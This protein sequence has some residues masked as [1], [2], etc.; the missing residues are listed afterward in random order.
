M[1]R[2]DKAHH[3][4]ACASCG[5]PLRNLKAMPVAKPS[6]PA[7]SHQPAPLMQQPRRKERYRPRKKDRRRKS[8]LWE[9]AEE[10]FDFVED[11]FD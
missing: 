5:A 10:A 8:W 2:H 9:V 1:L 4:L 6:R 11:I 3:T 7:I